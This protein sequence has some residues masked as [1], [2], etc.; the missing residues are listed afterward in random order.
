MVTWPAD[1]PEVHERAARS[2]MEEPLVA[3]LLAITG[4]ALLSRLGVD[5]YRL[6]FRTAL[7]RVLLATVVA[8]RTAAGR[9]RPRA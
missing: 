9:A 2:A 5:G 8:A 1:E 3:L 4:I 7:G 6:L